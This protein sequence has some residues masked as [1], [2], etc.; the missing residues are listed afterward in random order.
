[1]FSPKNL[2]SK[3]SLQIKINL[4]ALKTV[5][6]MQRNISNLLLC[7]YSELSLIYTYPTPIWDLLIPACFLT[8][9]FVAGVLYTLLDTESNIK[10]YSLASRCF[11]LL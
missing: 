6:Q 5:Y 3:I 9:D 4:Q 7:P 8:Q 10:S 11:K 2:F 1:M